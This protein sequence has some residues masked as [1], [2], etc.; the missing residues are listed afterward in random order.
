MSDV[1]ILDA[2]E[3]VQERMAK[4]VR[5]MREKKK[6]KKKNG[7]Q[8]EGTSLV[9][10]DEIEDARIA[11]LSKARVHAVQRGLM[12]SSSNMSGG[13]NGASE[14]AI[15][16]IKKHEKHAKKAFRQ[17]EMEREQAQ[18]RLKKVREK[19]KIERGGCLIERWRR[20][21]RRIG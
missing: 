16:L 13:G 11:D 20:A 12:S 1:A 18:K 19:K 7:D 4:Q 17:A 8:V 2:D 21:F 14:N 6:K 9:K 15:E 3:F 10:I 5:D